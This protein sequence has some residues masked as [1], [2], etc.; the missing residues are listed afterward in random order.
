MLTRI[1]AFSL[2]QPLLI[3]ALTALLVGVGLWSA[4]HLSI[5]A[6]PD[7]TNVQVQINT[8]APALSPVE[9]ERQITFPVE[10]AMAGLPGVDEVRSLSK[11]GLSQVTVVFKDDV[12]IYFAR[13]LVQERLQLARDEIPPGLGM[14]GMGP[15][16]TGLGE[17]FQYTVESPTKDLTELRTLQDWIVKRQ[18]RTVPGVAEVNSFGGFEKQYHVLI[19][20]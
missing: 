6:V 13:Q 16:S 19:R 15:I 7:V 9:V 4:A 3:L 2:R 14:P 20:P 10:V 1:L 17:I 8:N 11:F 18:L 5:D 12:N